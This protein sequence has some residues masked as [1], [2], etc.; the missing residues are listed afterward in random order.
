MKRQRVGVTAVHS[1]FFFTLSPGGFVSL[2]SDYNSLI[3]VYY[4]TCA[5]ISYAL[6]LWADVMQ[7]EF[8]VNVTL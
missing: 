3:Y 1:R 6:F 5:T 7:A 4:I 2:L 8:H